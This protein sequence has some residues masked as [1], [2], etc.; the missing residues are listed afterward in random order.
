MVEQPIMPLL[1]FFEL[2]MV[3][4]QWTGPLLLVVESLLDLLL[5]EGENGVAPKTAKSSP[6]FFYLLIFYHSVDQQRSHLLY[7]QR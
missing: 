4:C 3:W 2:G 7:R 6:F 5:R 1:P